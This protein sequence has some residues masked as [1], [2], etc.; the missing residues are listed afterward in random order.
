MW[1]QAPTPGQRPSPKRDDQEVSLLGRLLKQPQPG[2]R[3]NRRQQAEAALPY[4]ALAVAAL[5]VVKVVLGKRD[6]AQKSQKATKRPTAL[7]KNARAAHQQH[8]FDDWDLLTDE[9][10]QELTKQLEAVDLAHVNAIFERS[11][12]PASEATASPVEDVDITK[13]SE[14]S[15]SSELDYIRT[16]LELI[17]KDQVAVVLL[18]GGQGTRLGSNDPKGCYD[19]GLPSS[20][21]LFQLHAERI[22]R[23]QHVAALHDAKGRKPSARPLIKWYIMTSSATDAATRAYFEQKKNFGL[24]KSQV[25]FFQQGTL[26][27]LTAEGKVIMASGHSLA[28]AP[29]GNGGVFTALKRSGM[30]KD[31]AS[32]GV[33][34][35]DC[36][37]VDNALVRPADPLF[38]GLCHQHEAECGSRVLA[39]L[40]A[41][42][43]VGVFARRNDR[44]QVIEYSELDADDASS[45]DPSTGLLRY[46]WSNVCMHYFSVAFLERIATSLQD[47]MVH[48][49]AHKSI[50]S[51]DGPVRGVKL[52]QFIFDPFPHARAQVLLEVARDE[53]FAPVKNA[54][55]SASDSPDTACAALLDLHTRWVRAAGGTVKLEGNRQPSVVEVAPLVSYAGEGLQKLCQD[56][57]LRQPFDVFLQG[58]VGAELVSRRASLEGADRGPSSSP[59]R[60]LGSQ[61]RRS[62]LCTLLP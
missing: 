16:G 62:G 28:T 29:D 44:L 4:V 50:P 35:V 46:N 32:K 26:P 25:M 33:V 30:L 12:Q 57:T 43:R 56:R 20:R 24:D 13:L 15:T 14:L 60:A 5:S 23:L 45:S 49:L 1:G 47:S 51:K 55:G 36:V 38:L 7:W 31:M 41:R 53:Q 52:E 34:C 9:Q 48:H 11:N 40:H 18:A 61:H 22:K 54:P 42:E 59:Q 27:C 21:S 10:R 2:K 17:L 58:T 19:I 8:I 37:S 3:Q 39:R 6:Q